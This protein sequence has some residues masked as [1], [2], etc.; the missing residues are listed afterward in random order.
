MS[1]QVSDLM[2]LLCTTSKS[3]PTSGIVATLSDS[4]CSEVESDFSFP[5]PPEIAGDHSRL[6][7]NSL[8]LIVQDTSGDV[9]GQCTSY[10]I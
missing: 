1:S 5:A 9:S 10:S 2:T 4:E 3:C 7:S 6:D 8:Q